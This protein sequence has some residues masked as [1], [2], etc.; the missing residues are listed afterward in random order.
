MEL[1]ATF[2]RTCVVI[3]TLVGAYSLFR[4][5]DLIV[6]IF[7]G[8]IFASTIRPL[9]ALMTRIKIPRALVLILIYGLTIAA[10]ILLFVIAVPPVVGLA[11]D[12]SQNSRLVN[13]LNVALVQIG[14][15]LRRQFEVYVPILTLPPRF[16]AFLS[17][18]DETMA[19]QAWP[20]AQGAAYTVSQLVL[21]TVISIYWLLSGQT[22]LRQMVRLTGP[23][24]RRTIYRIWTDT[25]DAL[26]TYVRGQLTLALAIGMAAYIGLWVL[27]VPN[28]LALA[29][30]AGMFEVVPFVG[31]VAAVIPAFLM[32]LTVSPVAAGL[33]LLWYMIVQQLEGSFL[34]PRVMG[35]GLQLHPLT[36]LIAI[37]A[38]YTLNGIVGA[39]LA[40]PLASALQITVRHLRTAAAV[41]AAREN[42]GP[43]ENDEPIDDEVVVPSGGLARTMIPADTPLGGSPN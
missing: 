38:G 21:A 6:V 12:L 25:E 42:S 3:A 30:L 11:M 28:A 41:A 43:A 19:Q 14:L 26:G 33:I 17:S 1:R 2:L 35:R 24:Y 22:A 32:A 15:L 37:V 31:P 20:F 18:A 36:V 29:V 16:Q 13:S 7:V 23:R 39:M 27:Q 34:V 10:L 4:L 8:I 40:L 9:M 5:A